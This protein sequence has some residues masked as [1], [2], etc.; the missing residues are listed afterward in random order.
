MKNI[1]L[2]VVFVGAFSVL[3]LSYYLFH[4]SGASARCWYHTECRAVRNVHKYYPTNK[5]FPTP[6]I[7]IHEL[8]RTRVRIRTRTRTKVCDLL[9]TLQYLNRRTNLFIWRTKGDDHYSMHEHGY[10][11]WTAFVYVRIDPYEHYLFIT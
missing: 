6:Q 10:W 9:F 7:G 5:S 11:T 2:D 1:H 3:Q 4:V 8:N